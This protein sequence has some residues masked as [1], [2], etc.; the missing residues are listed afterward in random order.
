VN[1]SNAKTA[2]SCISAVARSALLVVLL[3][4]AAGVSQVAKNTIFG[5]EMLA[6]NYPNTTAEDVGRALQLT[7]TIGGHS[8]HI[9]FL[10]DQDR[11]A[12]IPLITSVMR[13]AGLKVMLQIG[14][15]LIDTPAPP[16]GMVQSFGD[17]NVRFVYLMSARKLA[18]TKPDYLVLCTEANLLYRFN[19]P[20]FENF[21]TLYTQMY[22]MVKS[23]SPQTKVGASYLYTV[24]FLDRFFDN[25]DV[26]AMLTPYDMLSFTGYPEDIIN[27]GVYDS[28]ASMSPEWYGAARYAYPNATIGF[29]EIGWSSKVRGTP[30]LQA[31][32]VR[33]LPRLMSTVKP[34]FITWAVLHDV[35]FFRRSLLTAEQI[36]FL[37]GLGVDIDT[38]FGHFNGMGLLDGQGNAKPAFHEAEQL[39]FPKP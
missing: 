33:N 11:L 13:Q 31:E 8:S 39:V 30:E 38:L 4:P 26:P 10:A 15:V 7:A 29:S 37:E 21:R 18:L 1:A 6:A 28:I 20:E 35:E 27:A 3:L 19:R 24:W 32:F 22:N 36:A 34:E 12:D 5:A 14:S 25:V 17:P 16:V 9:W 2:L 23:V